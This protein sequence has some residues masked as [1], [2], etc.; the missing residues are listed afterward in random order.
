DGSGAQYTQTTFSCNRSTRSAGERG[1]DIARS[2]LRRQFRVVRRG[3][4]TAEDDPVRTACDRVARRV[5]AYLI[6]QVATR[7]PDARHHRAQVA[8]TRD[9]NVGAGAHDTVAPCAGG[10]LNSRLERVDV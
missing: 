6:V 5:D 8:R 3:D 9:R 4:C 1:G 7:E 2:L 10:G